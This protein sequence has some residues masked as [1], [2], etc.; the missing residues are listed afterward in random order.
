[1]DIELERTGWSRFRKTV[2]DSINLLIPRQGVMP[3][4]TEVYER[5]QRK[6]TLDLIL[7]IVLATSLV[8]GIFNLQFE[9]LASILALFGLA[10]LCVPLLILNSRDHYQVAAAT[11]SLIV[12]MAININLY[13]GDGIRDP[14]LLAYPIFIMTG[15]LFF[16]RRAA[17]YFSAAAVISAGVIIFLEIQGEVIPTIGPTTYE[18]LIP[19]GILFLV[20]A[21]IIWV[22]VGN[23]DKNLDLANKSMAELRNNYDLTLAAWAQV[24]EYRDRETVGHSRRLVDLSTRLGR[25]LG[26]SEEQIVDLQ[27]GA[28][29]HDIGKLAIP[30][31]ILLK[32]N[33]L[34]EDERRLIRRHPQ[35]AS[36]ML[37]GIPFLKP[38]LEVAHSHHE[39]WDGSGY[40]EALKQEQI[41]L[42]ARVF[43][44]VD[45]WDALNSERVYRPRWSEDESRKY[46]KENAGILYDPHIVEVFLSIV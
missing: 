41:P 43:A 17:P 42:L 21:T 11:L 40:P 35:Y 2:T 19:I 27:R 7:W 23:I 38:A 18:I 12:L 44:V 24:L 10:V 9:D 46:I 25:A 16:G 6:R 30:D 26:L 13:D 15:T 3:E 20:W 5:D 14:G 1:M 31:D 45:T 32:N 36:Q 34:T 4:V 39:R 37:A 33:V 28:I 29:I 8:L 22:I